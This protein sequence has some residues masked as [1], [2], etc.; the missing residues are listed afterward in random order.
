MGIYSY[1]PRATVND[2]CSFV[3]MGKRLLTVVAEPRLTGV[4]SFLP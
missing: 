2:G 1:V 3:R 4:R